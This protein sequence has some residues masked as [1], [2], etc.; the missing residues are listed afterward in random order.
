[1]RIKRLDKVILDDEGNRC[2]ANLAEFLFGDRKSGYYLNRDYNLKCYVKYEEIMKVFSKVLKPLYRSYETIQKQ[3]EAFLTLPGVSEQIMYCEN[4]NKGIDDL[5]LFDTP[6]NE[7]RFDKITED[8]LT[9]DQVCHSLGEARDAMKYTENHCAPKSINHD[10]ESTNDVRLAIEPSQA[11]VEDADPPQKPNEEVKS[12]GSIDDCV[13]DEFS[14]HERNS[15]NKD[16]IRK[17]L[18]LGYST[19]NYRT[20]LIPKVKCKAIEMKKNLGI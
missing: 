15:V 17:K 7:V 10:F 14:E 3:Y 20:S 19:M 4:L 11:I 13:F 5:Q 16:N 12:N 9:P 6:E 2:P 8:E 18:D 1:M